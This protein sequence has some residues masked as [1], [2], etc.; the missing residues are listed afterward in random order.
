MCVFTKENLNLNTDIK[1][2]VHKN[3]NLQLT[4]IL[5]HVTDVSRGGGEIT[6]FRNSNA[7]CLGVLVQHSVLHLTTGF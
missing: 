2:C 4:N 6:N 5:C 7:L 3:R 1:S